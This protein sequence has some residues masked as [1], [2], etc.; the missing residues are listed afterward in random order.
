MI[1]QTIPIPGNI[2]YTT[3]T[4]PTNI[5]G[6]W[7][8]DTE[9]YHVE[10]TDY[11]ITGPTQD[12]LDIT[13]SYNVPSTPSLITLTKDGVT[14]SV[15]PSGASGTQI[16]TLSGTATSGNVVITLTVDGEQLK[17]VIYVAAFSPLFQLGQDEDGCVNAWITFDTAAPTGSVDKDMYTALQSLGWTDCIED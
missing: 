10:I 12:D 3:G 2:V 9:S 11:E 6:T 5:P 14:N 4:T 15:T 8:R 7:R 17:H 13:F 16:G 1:N